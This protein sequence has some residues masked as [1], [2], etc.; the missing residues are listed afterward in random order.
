MGSG[1]AFEDLARLELRDNAHAETVAISVVAAGVSTALPA[2]HAFRLVNTG[3]KWCYVRTGTG[4]TTC[5]ATNGHPVA[6]D[7][8][9]LNI[10]TRP[11]AG[12]DTHLYSITGGSDSTVLFCCPA[13]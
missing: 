10:K 5:T 9:E 2:G 3:T 7:G 13:D 4:A 12:A 1:I 8:G 11:G 6:P